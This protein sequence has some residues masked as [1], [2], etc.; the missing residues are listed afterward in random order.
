MTTGQNQGAFPYSKK[1]IPSARNFYAFKPLSFCMTR[2]SCFAAVNSFPV[3][4]MLRET[5]RT[6]EQCAHKNKNAPQ[7]TGRTLSGQK[8]K[9]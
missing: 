7:N 5:Y 4:Q 2:G 3:F 6:G 8:K 9:N 1:G